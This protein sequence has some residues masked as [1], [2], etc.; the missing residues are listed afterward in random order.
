MR[1][2]G[3][4]SGHLQSLLDGECDVF[5]IA[6]VMG[7]KH[8]C[9]KCPR[10]AIERVRNL[11]EAKWSELG[12]TEKRRFIEC[13]ADA[14]SDLTYGYVVL[15]RSDLIS[16]SGSYL[17]HNDTLSEEG[18][19]LTV[20][21]WCYAE[22]IQQLKSDWGRIRFTFDKYFHQPQSEQLEELVS[23]R[24]VD[25][26]SVSYATS[27]SEKGIQAADCLAG[28]VS[29]CARGKAGWLQSLPATAVENATEGT[30]AAI[31]NELLE[32]M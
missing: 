2:Y 18:W 3:D 17:F 12:S 32:L 25:R 29:D 14:D 15:D 9:S 13:F 10:R 30:L 8:T 5:V 4:E 1:I 19:D 20:L 7:K 21:G 6:V 24:T 27:H 22:L 16:L 31:Q 23:Q 26:V 11:E 28:A